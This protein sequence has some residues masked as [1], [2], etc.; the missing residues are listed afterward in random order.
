MLKKKYRLVLVDKSRT[1][2][3]LYLYEGAW[4]TLT[5][6]Y[7][8]VKSSDITYLCVFNG[9]LLV[10]VETLYKFKQEYQ[11]ACRNNLDTTKWTS[12]PLHSL[13]KGSFELLSRVLLERLKQVDPD[14]TWYTDEPIQ[15]FNWN[16]DCIEVF[17]GELFG[18]IMATNSSNAFSQIVLCTQTCIIIPQHTTEEKSLKVKLVSLNHQRRKQNVR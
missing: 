10:P 5:R 11:E 16:C 18:R 3:T 13:T 2:N 6:L 14:V 9:D 4:L 12:S 1:I 15:I 7:K 17:N 8:A